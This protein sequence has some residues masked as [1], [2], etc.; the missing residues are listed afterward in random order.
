MSAAAMKI[1]FIGLGHMG[2][3]MVKHLIKA[4]HRVVCVELN[5]A[6]VKAATDA[7]AETAPVAEMAAQCDVV[8]TVLPEG[9]H[10]RAVYLGPEGVIENARAGTLL[11]DCST[12]DVTTSQELSEAAAAH[13]TRMLDAP[14][15]GGVGGAATASLTFMVGGR[16]EDFA[17]AE[18]ILSLMGTKLV[19][20]GGHGMGQA[21]K[22]VNNLVLAI[23]MAG[24]AEAYALGEKLGLDH[25]TLFDVTSTSSAQCWS[26][27][28]YCPLPDVVPSSP[29][30]RNF[31]PG[32]TCE[33]M[34]KDLRLALDA[35]ISQG[36]DSPLGGVVQKLYKNFCARDGAGLDFS[37]IIQFYR[38]NS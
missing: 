27:N 4:G 18:P 20:A 2:S 7:G 5:A 13:E 25:K 23:S 38:K 31:E 32:F 9:K 28:S 24:V 10:S 36:H 6:S 35:A 1:G 16:R 29:A 15:S 34:E 37:G 12:I 3:E 33:M 17:A 8:L 21:V 30:N 22:M 19:H 26:I 14:V 11:I